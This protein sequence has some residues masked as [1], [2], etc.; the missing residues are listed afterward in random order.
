M[1][2]TPGRWS[3]HTEVSLSET[4]RSPTEGK[5]ILWLY[6]LFSCLWIKTILLISIMTS[7]TRTFRITTLRIMTLI[8]T[9]NKFHTQHNDTQHVATAPVYWVWPMLSVLYA[10]LCKIS[11]LWR[12]LLYWMLLCWVSLWWVSWRHLWLSLLWSFIYLENFY[13]YAKQTNLGPVLNFYSH[14]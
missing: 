8:L 14:K 2:N 6:S 13:L 1:V 5:G 12:V 3:L 4:I 10:E 9:T 11:P 7:S